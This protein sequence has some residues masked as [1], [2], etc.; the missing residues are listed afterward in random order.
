MG[1]KVIIF[2]GPPRGRGRARQALRYQFGNYVS[3]P[4]RILGVALFRW[5]CA[6]RAIPDEVIL[7]GSPRSDWDMVH[8]LAALRHDDPIFSRLGLR[9]SIDAG[10]VDQAM[11]D[12]LSQFLGGYLGGTRVR[13]I[14]GA[15]H[16][17]GR[18]GQLRAH[19]LFDRLAQTGDE[20][21]V[22]VTH[23]SW[24]GGMF[25]VAA[26]THLSHANIGGLYL[27]Q[28]EE[29]SPAGTPVLIMK[30]INRMVE[31]SNAITL[32][33]TN[34][35]LG[36]LPEFLGE[37]S[38]ELGETLR[39]INF[40]IATQQYENL[41]ENFQDCLRHLRAL[42]SSQRETLAV[43]HARQLLKEANWL[44]TAHLADW[45][46]EFARRAL[47]SMDYLR[48]ATLAQESVVSAAIARTRQRTDMSV[49]MRVRAELLDDRN[50][51]ALYPV[52][53]WPFLTL[54]EV[55]A[56]LAGLQ[57]KQATNL[58]P[59]LKDES[60]LRHFLERAISFAAVLVARFRRVPPY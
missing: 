31:W 27:A 9:V 48:A 32:F 23:D 30:D 52:D 41:Y 50:R 1:L 45:Q 55:R 5:L 59:I 8:E 39:A 58:R 37:E 3:K 2:L 43:F 14:L 56:A 51:K 57:P 29:T 28:D 21:H 35:L 40:G 7:I 53:P 11:L 33:H 24:S 12:N 49:R 38:P 6:E 20:C 19:A 22:D 54:W 4:S 26:S 44:E 46:I 15:E 34:G 47:S 18:V 60:S 16:V 17:H 25:S 42:A 13:C 36:R 10:R